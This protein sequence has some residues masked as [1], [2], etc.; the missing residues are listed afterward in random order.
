MHNL[1]QPI[2][3][4]C[5]SWL[6]WCTMQSSI[7]SPR[8]GYGQSAPPVERLPLPLFAKLS[9]RVLFSSLLSPLNAQHSPMITPHALFLRPYKVFFLTLF[10]K[11]LFLSLLF[12]N[13]SNC[14]QIPITTLLVLF[15]PTNINLYLILSSSSP[16]SLTSSKYLIFP[17]SVAALLS[18]T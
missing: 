4:Y 14:Q 1:I 12:L 7:S 8:S 18:C 17:Y 10:P 2:V 3:L 9:S 16:S 6:L 15:P 13:F 5:G 11:T